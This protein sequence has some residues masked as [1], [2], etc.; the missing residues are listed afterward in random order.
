MKT[1][2]MMLIGLSATVA[3]ACGEMENPRV[4]QFNNATVSNHSKIS[5][6][7]GN[8]K[9]FYKLQFDMTQYHMD[10]NC[11]LDIDESSTNTFPDADC[12]LKDGDKKSG[13]LSHSDYGPFVFSN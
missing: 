1:L 10:G 11:G 2:I 7:S 9:C 8:S 13:I 12:S 3:L 6:G 4:V 5:D